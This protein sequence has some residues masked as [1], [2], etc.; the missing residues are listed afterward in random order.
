MD[1]NASVPPHML[2]YMKENYG[3]WIDSVNEITT[4]GSYT[5]YP[6]EESGDNL[7]RI[8]TGYSNEY[9]YLEYRKQSG[10]YES[11]LPD[12]GLLVYRIDFDYN[13]QGNSEGYYG[14]DGTS[15]NEVFLFRPGISDMIPPITFPSNPSNDDFDGDLTEAALSN[16]NLYDSAGGDSDI[17][18]F[19]SD[20]SL[21]DIKIT[22]V[23]EHTGYITFDVVLQTSI[24]LVLDGQTDPSSDVYLWNNSAMNYQIEILNVG[25]YQA[26]YTLDGT[27]PTTQSMPYVGPVHI[28]A[29]HHL[30][31]VAIYDDQSLIDTLER[32]F[33][34]VNQIA[35]AHN[36]YGDMINTTWI[37]QPNVFAQDFNILFDNRSELE[38]DYDYLYITYQGTTD[39]YTATELS[40][41][42]LEGIDS[43]LIINLVTDEYVS[44]YYGFS[45]TATFDQVIPLVLNG[46]TNMIL[47]PSDIYQEPGATIDTSYIGDYTL[48]IDENLNPALTT[49]QLVYYTLIDDQGF[50]AYTLTRTVSFTTDDQLPTFDVIADQTVEI[51][52][53]DFDWSTL[54]TNASDN[55]VGELIKAEQNDLVNYEQLGTYSVTVSVTDISNNTA[56]RTFLVTVVDT[57]GP[58]LSLNPG[59]DS[60]LV[61][62]SYMDYGIQVF[63]YTN[64]NT[65]ITG[66][67]DAATAGIYILTYT[68]TDSSMNESQIVRYVHVTENKQQVSFTLG[69]AKTTLVVGDSYS[70][71]SCSV[72]IGEETFTCTVKENTVNT[73][74]IGTYTITYSYTY[75]N[76]EYTI[77][78]YVFIYGQTYRI[79]E[80]IKEEEVRYA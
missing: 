51:G 75:Q 50:I 35:S 34:F 44:N 80:Y 16:L 39:I 63:D 56:T 68:V 2:G 46:D 62:D 73:Q 45:I 28:D 43:T 29:L 60:I 58:V 4:S 13:G 25:N 30:V 17:M 48:R 47:G 49:Q 24:Q 40:T 33:D 52:S 57:T 65:T 38:E 32:D 12:S 7:Y 66:S 74:A 11:Q 26:Y 8:N 72:Q 54:I 78:R 70:D 19:Y 69:F 6:L 20:G 79:A 14:T 76:T 55:S 18:M 3:N 37:I 59:L 5:L 31:K 10:L 61:G 41:L 21:M 15:S 71:G 9:V 64:T 42:L 27:T 23:V 36:D 67:V 53:L 77:K 1:F 22:N